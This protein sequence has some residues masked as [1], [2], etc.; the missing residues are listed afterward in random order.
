MVG[1]TRGDRAPMNDQSAGQNSTV[2]ER[3]LTT[4][5]EYLHFE[6]VSGVVLLAATAVAMLWANSPLTDSYHEIWHYRV[7][8]GTS[9]FAFARPLH[10]WINDALMAVFFLVVGMAIR[11][12]LHEG[13]LS[14]L[15]QAILPVLAALG[16]V[17]VPALIYLTFNAGDGRS[18]GW[19]VPTAT[20]IAFA[21]GVLALLGRS[22]PANVRVFLL[23]TSDHRRH[24]RS[25]YHCPVLHQRH[26]SRRLRSGG[27]GRSARSRTATLR[28]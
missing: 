4:L 20:D 15:D 11:R 14:Q 23:S 16:G 8:I 17:I 24:H 13:A 12:E 10:F 26:R 25:A 19:A 18:N 28:L 22:I 6:A 5:K 7:S 27:G 9:S 3:A 2:V 21:V 1:P